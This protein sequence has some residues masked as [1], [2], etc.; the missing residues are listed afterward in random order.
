MVGI[1]VLKNTGINK[2]TFDLSTYLEFPRDI[3][4]D[5]NLGCPTVHTYVGKRITFDLSTYLEFPRD[6]GD[7]KNLGC[8]MVHT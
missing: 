7:N 5:K 4:D 3:R 6:I 2:N 1:I 8:P